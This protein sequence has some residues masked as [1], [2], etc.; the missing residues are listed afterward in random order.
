MYLPPL[1]ERQSRYLFTPFDIT[2]ETVKYVEIRWAGRDP[3]P[4]LE[5]FLVRHRVSILKNRDPPM[6][7][8]RT[9]FA[10]A[11]FTAFVAAAG[12][13]GRPTEDGVFDTQI[14]PLLEQYCI[15]CHG[16]EKVKGEVDFSE[17]VRS[18]DIDSRFELWETVADV[19]A[20]EE[21]PPEE[22]ENRPDPTETQQILDWYEERFVNSMEARPGTFQ[23]R[24]LSANEYRNTLRSLFGFDLENQIIAAEQTFVEKSLVIKLL[25][26]D[27]P[28]P[29]EFVNDTSDAR[30]S[31]FI[32]EQYAYMADRAL[33]EL[34]SKERSAALETLVGQPLPHYSESI[35]LTPAQAESLLRS[36]APRALRRPIAR[37]ELKRML[38]SLR[39]LKG[40][41]LLSA[42]RNEM[43]ALL[44]SPSFLYRG[45]LIEATPGKQQLV[46]SYEL[47]ERLSYFLWEDMPDTQLFEAA[48]RGD[49]EHA[50]EI[51]K[52]V[53][54]MLASPRARNLAESF[55]HQW[56]GLADIDNARDDVL[57][58]Q[59]L[60]S[61]LFDFLNYLFTENRPVIELIDSNVAFASHNTAS[62]YPEN[63]HQLEKYVRPKG[64]ERKLVPNQRMTLDPPEGRG[65]ILTMPG[66]LAMNRGPVLRGT[67]MLR[68]IL[69]ERLGEPPADIPPVEAA[70]PNADL[71]F[72]ER[73]EVHR[74]DSTC[75]RC[76]DRIDPL[77]FALQMYDDEGSYKLALDYK[78]PRRRAGHDDDPDRID[79]S[80]QI[81]GGEAFQNFDELKS[82]LLGSKRRDI[83]RNAVERTLAYA[84]CRKLEAF[85]RPTIDAIT[86]KIDETNGT[87]RDL[88]VEVS[89][90]LPFRETF[91]APSPQTNS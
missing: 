37:K 24:R 1:V 56:L 2:E 62:F 47:A 42:T 3:H 16:G 74:R 22:E 90:S 10:S 48:A 53:D 45:L 35:E 79:T 39:G 55:G 54:R 70:A 5:S 40:G 43:K 64:I 11:L 36:F 20:Y 87:W 58:R 28:G 12:L 23:A 85:D 80:G 4:Y 38:A 14:Q 69:G 63:N 32:W 83:I 78:P 9:R 26:T 75:A 18:Q 29:S 46:D 51:A 68:R 31:S 30:L 88:F 57:S 49:L 65:G 84:L 17:I 21:M 33:Q 52:Q 73:F 34:F 66:I 7:H 27:P 13:E 76:H 60:R 41:E 59:A 72:R 8:T 81:P 67:W 15:N 89:Q 71:S 77:G 86:E 61:Q 25:P 50:D 44:V 91:I 82:I 19:L 6:I